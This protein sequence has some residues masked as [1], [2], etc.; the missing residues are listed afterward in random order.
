MVLF[1][2]ASAKSIRDEEGFEP[3]R[4][5][6]C[7]ELEIHPAHDLDK[8]RNSL[9]SCPLCTGDL[10]KIRKTRYRCARCQWRGL[11]AEAQLGAR[12]A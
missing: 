8:P 3:C 9:P 7:K 6:K 1:T 2:M 10:I 5:E 4:D 11:L 12:N